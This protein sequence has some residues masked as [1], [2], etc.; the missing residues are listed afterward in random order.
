L[1]KYAKPIK[2]PMDLVNIF[3]DLTNSQKRHFKNGLRNVFNFYEAQGL[4]DKGWLDVLR[5]NLPKTSIGIDLNIPTADDIAKSLKLLKA[6]KYFALYN[7]TL[8]SG[9]RL[10]EALRLFNSLR[11]NKIEIEG[12]NGFYIAPLGYFRGTKV[13]YYGFIT[14]FTMRL[15]KEAKGGLR[16]VKIMGALT[17]KFENVISWKYLRKFAFDIM[18]SESLNIPES[19]AD[20][21]QGRTPKSIGARHYM[22][23]KRKAVQF[24]PRYAEYIT[25]LRQKGGLPTPV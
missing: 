18:T 21:I 7:L 2:E 16:Y 15:I 24:Y 9:L 14:E 20:F 12:N 4:A 25:Q 19:V 3:K 22:Q 5:K 23:L 8:D 6:S 13:A 10:T 1:E 11:E 17:K